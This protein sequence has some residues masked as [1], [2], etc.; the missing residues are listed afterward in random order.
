MYHFIRPLLFSYN[1]QEIHKKS[2]E[3]GKKLKKLRVS[4]IIKAVY[5]FQDKRLRVRVKLVL[6]LVLIRMVN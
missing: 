5:D 4:S 1:A 6:L 3:I 2:I